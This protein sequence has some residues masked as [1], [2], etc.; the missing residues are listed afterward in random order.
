MQASVKSPWGVSD[1][2]ILAVKRVARRR[3]LWEAMQTPIKCAIYS[4]DRAL[5]PHYLDMLIFGCAIV[6]QDQVARRSERIIHHISRLRLKL[7]AEG[8]LNA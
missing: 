1:R 8:K 6:S 2:E 4:I 5:N 7:I 3:D